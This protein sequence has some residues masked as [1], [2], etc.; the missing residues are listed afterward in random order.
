MDRRAWLVAIS[1]GA[2]PL[3]PAGKAAHLSPASKTIRA[4]AYGNFLS[5]LKAN[6]LL[7]PVV[8]VASRIQAEWVRG[9]YAEFVARTAPK[10]SSTMLINFALAVEAMEPN[11]R[12]DWIRH[13]SCKPSPML[14]RMSAQ[15]QRAVIDTA[16]LAVK[17]L[18]R[19][20]E[21]MTGP[22]T[23]D[24]AIEFRDL[25][26]VALTCYHAPRLGNLAGMRLGEQLIRSEDGK[27]RLHFQRTKNGMVLPP[28]LGKGL[29]APLEHYLT[30]LRPLLLKNQI[31]SN[32]VWIN[33]R[34]QKL[35]STAFRGIF[36]RV[37]IQLGSPDLHPHA[38]RHGMATGLLQRDPRAVKVAA[39]AL[40][41]RSTASVN[42]VYDRSGS[43][44]AAEE[45]A[46][47]LKKVRG[48]G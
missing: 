42:R 47:T 40:A 38:C 8:D 25:L 23:R 41:H 46:R 26:L 48:G 6:D 36:V 2:T 24:L 32:C 18:A 27:W 11:G 19:C 35:A 34:G 28:K 39:A 21:M 22:P 43:T 45:W 17:A 7:H 1:P 33:A 16:A 12:W 44:I 15:N 29:E 3:D 13:Q 14:I 30:M 20:R 5:W 4:G 9:W 37:G 10:T 31:D